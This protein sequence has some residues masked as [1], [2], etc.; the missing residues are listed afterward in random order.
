MTR[1]PHQE[2]QEQWDKC[3][4]HWGKINKVMKY[5]DLPE[6]DTSDE[7]TNLRYVFKTHSIQDSLWAKESAKIVDAKL[8]QV[9][10]FVEYPIRAQMPLAFT[11][12]ISGIGFNWGAIISKQL[13][14]CIRY[15]QVLKEADTPSFYMAS[16]ILDVIYARNFFA[17]MN[18]NWHSSELRSMYTSA[19][20]GKIGTRNPMLLSVISL[21]HAFTSCSLGNNAPDCQLKKRRL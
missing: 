8:G 9:Q 1:D 21:L 16:Y 12:S 3:H 13:S 2:I 4:K 6:F 17:W 19:Y 15:A 20:Y 7:F 11:V 5:D 10:Q 18:L 14:T